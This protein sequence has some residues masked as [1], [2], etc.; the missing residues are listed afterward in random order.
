MPDDLLRFVDGPPAS[1]LAW[2]W[3]PA[4]LVLLLIGWYVTVFAITAPRTGDGVVQRTRDALARRRF[5]G[6]IRRIRARLAAGDVDAVEASAAL[7]RTLR[8][9]LQRATGS[10][11]EYMQIT[12]LAESEL[13]DTAE[14]FT[15][16]DDVRFNTRSDE[17]VAEL[18]AA[19][20]EVIAS[21]T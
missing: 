20:E 2:L 6:E 4:V 7:N 12:A 21:W 11:V 18:G 14:L 15:R 10:P 16:L 3:L 9:F 1:A 17:D 8:E 5:L 13:A 19:A